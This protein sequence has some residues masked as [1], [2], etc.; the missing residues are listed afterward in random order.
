M[1]YIL[2]FFSAKKYM[3]GGVKKWKRWKK[4]NKKEEKN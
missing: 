2:Y 3:N 4:Q 1:I